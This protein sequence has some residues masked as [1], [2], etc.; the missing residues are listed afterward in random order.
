MMIIKIMKVLILKQLR[1]I[2]GCVQFKKAYYLDSYFNQVQNDSESQKKLACRKWFYNNLNY[3][4]GTPTDFYLSIAMEY[5]D[6]T[7]QDL[8]NTRLNLKTPWNEG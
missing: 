7:L 8:I 5:C 6:C 1:G 3:A 2:Q 4:E